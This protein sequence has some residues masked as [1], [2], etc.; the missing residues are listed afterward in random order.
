MNNHPRRN[1][2]A[3]DVPSDAAPS[4][5]RVQAKACLPDGSWLTVEAFATEEDAPTRMGEVKLSGNKLFSHFVRHAVIL[6]RLEE[7]ESAIHRV[8]FT[9]SSPAGLAQGHPH[10]E[11]AGRLLQ[12]AAV[13]A[14]KACRGQAVVPPGGLVVWACCD[15]WT[16]GT[17]IPVPAPWHL[18]GLQTL[19]A[20]DAAWMQRALVVIAAA[21]EAAQPGV[22]AAVAAL[23]LAHPHLADVRVVS[24]LRSVA[25]SLSHRNHTRKGEAW[26]PVL[27]GA[28]GVELLRLSVTVVP[29]SEASQAALGD[30][31]Q[32]VCPAIA[33]TNDRQTTVR[34]VLATTR[35]L[36]PHAKLWE[37]V[38]D[39]PAT[40]FEGNSY[41]LALAMAD[42]IARGREW[43]GPGRVLA[44]GGVDTSDSHEEGTVLDV[45]DELKE[46]AQ[47]KWAALKAHL[48][49]GDTVLL[50]K[51]W[52]KSF[53]PAHLLNTCPGVGEWM[54]PVIAF[55][56]H[57]LPS[58]GG[59]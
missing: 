16:T 45:L 24:H 59:P 53:T 29:R 32:V 42:R 26:F 54:Q 50:P 28:G 9:L 40:G 39:L 55:V 1:T 57:V 34:L 31:V 35:R 46:G 25:G 27:T 6:S 37:T 52:Q 38:V 19:A 13:L 10:C 41:Q 3:S 30:A 48:Q 36:D 20:A 17:L 21:D 14:D 43:A 33:L 12:T 11:L 44:T 18:A 15:D 47:G 22:D 49:P 8:V 7:A 2:A 51:A 4:N 23:R 56:G 5:N 58:E